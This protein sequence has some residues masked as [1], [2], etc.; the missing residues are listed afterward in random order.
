[1]MM[2]NERVK[3][4]QSRIKRLF[5]SNQLAPTCSSRQLK[6]SAMTRG[7]Q[8]P[9]RNSAPTTCCTWW[10]QLLPSLRP[11]KSQQPNTD[12]PYD[13]HLAANSNRL[14]KQYQTVHFYRKIVR[15]VLNIGKVFMFSAFS[16]SALHQPARNSNLWRRVF[17]G[18]SLPWSLLFLLNR[19]PLR[20]LHLR[21]HCICFQPES[22]GWPFLCMF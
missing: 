17:M 3:G 22:H 2:T 15:H 19:R 5:W 7:A 13:H 21:R 1:M 4:K 18:W 9:G 8:W 10:W 14:I 11:D 12:P 20:H 6:S 16:F